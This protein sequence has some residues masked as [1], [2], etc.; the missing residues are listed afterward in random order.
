MIFKAALPFFAEERFQIQNCLGTGLIFADLPIVIDDQKHRLLG[1]KLFFSAHAASPSRETGLAMDDHAELSPPSR[2]IAHRQF[3]A[4][5][6]FYDLFADGKTK[7]RA[8]LPFRREKGLK[9]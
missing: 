1:S 6:D 8:L 4:V 5:G 3:S 2:V 9:N 7:A